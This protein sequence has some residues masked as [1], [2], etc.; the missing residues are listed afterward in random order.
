[1]LNSPKQETRNIE[2]GPKT[3]QYGIIEVPT[4]LVRHLKESGLGKTALLVLLNILAHQL[5]TRSR[6]SLREI[7][8][9]TGFSLATIHRAKSNLA[10]KGFITPLKQEW[11]WFP[12]AYNLDGMIEKA[13]AL[14][15]KKT[16]RKL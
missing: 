13:E 6:A 7:A 11:T 5:T 14:A 16:S 1:M 8:K 4:V 15:T 10:L 2:Y 12:T 9:D 3:I